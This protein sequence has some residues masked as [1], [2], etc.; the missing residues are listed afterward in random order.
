MP[1]A[2]AGRNSHNTPGHATPPDSEDV[3]ARFPSTRYQGSKRKLAGAILQQIRD[4]EYTTVL[5]A[6]GGTG[7][8]AYAFKRI[9]KEVTYNDVLPFNLQVG[10]AIIENDATT[11]IESEI[12]SVGERRSRAT[13]DDVIERTFDGIYF[14]A[15]ENRWLDTAAAN[16]NRLRGRYKRALA[17]HAVFQ[18]ALAKRPYNLF[19]RRNLYM[20]TADVRRGFGNKATWERSFDAHFR[21]FIAEANAAVFAGSRPC[22]AI[23]RD[24][25]GVGGDFDLVYLD[26]PYLNARGVGVDYAGFYHFLNGIVQYDRWTQLV[27]YRSKHRRLDAPLSP[28]CD[29]Q[30]FGSAFLEIVDR[31]RRSQI[32]VSYRSDGLPGPLELTGMLKQFKKTVQLRT[33]RPY[34]YALSPAKGI[35]EVLL[36]CT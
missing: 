2:T 27:D 5:D 15:A 24:A 11:L 29:A 7:S 17:W 10:R 33:I 30:R 26:P 34:R 13:Y 21:N 20:R 23:C 12:G 28:W 1:T 36:I 3:L 19:H 6:F 25:A 9:G 14:H 18:A 16:I 8:M 32:V 22:R 31:F 35:C 4:L